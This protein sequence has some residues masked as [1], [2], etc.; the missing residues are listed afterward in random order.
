MNKYDLV[1]AGA[2]PAGICAAVQAARYGLKVALIERYGC[3][4]GNLTIGCIG[5]ILGG[6]SKNP[7]LR[8]IEDGLCKER[9]LVPDFER[10]KIFLTDLI[11]SASVDLYLQT[12]VIGA[13]RNGDKITEVKVYGKGGEL[14]FEADVF[15]DATGD[16]D[17]AVQCGCE[18]EMGREG[19]GLVQPTTIMFVIDGI[20][21]E[22]TLTC[23]HE[24]HY[25]DL[26]D[27]REY[28]DLCHKACKS[29][30]LPENVNIV[31]LY[32]T[33]RPTER[34]VNA[35]QENKIDPLD[36]M[37]VYR[38]E[39]ALRRQMS[40]VVDFLKNN[41]PGFENIFIKYS[42][43]TLGVRE[44]R[45][46]KGRYTLTKE[47]LMS[48]REFPDAVVHKASFSLDIHNPDG[49]GQSENDEKCPSTPKPYDIPFAAMCPLGVSNLITA[50]RCISG[51]HVAHS[52]YRVMRIC[53]AMG[54]A[55][56]VA[57]YVMKTT[58]TN[59]LTLS[60]DRIRDLLV[61]EGVEL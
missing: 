22:Q 4:G 61:N 19:D 43:S 39:V 8:N 31:R 23:C 40:K 57:A 58:N 54:Q 15:V 53:M 55:A 27:G 51:T 10:A 56:G 36:P 59:T 45:R 1:V 34:M 33:G 50:G 46:I 11:Y 30:E 42:T 41:I 38:A 28:L 16:G 32:K 35:T 3:V 7:M 26:G 13:V 37:A 6:T 25:T 12:T 21:P 20:D 5:P 49:P 60:T 17:L 2:G 44:S 18:W 9:G 47:D 48:G 14:S 52:S 29:G 24:E